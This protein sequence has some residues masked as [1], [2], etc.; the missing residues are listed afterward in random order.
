MPRRFSG[1]SLSAPDAL[2]RIYAAKAVLRERA[3][4]LVPYAV[5]RARA[6]ARLSERRPFLRALRAWAPPAVIAEIK[7][8][9]PSAGRIAAHFDV[10]AIAR[11]YEAAGAAAVSVLTERDNFLGDI[12]HLDLARGATSLPLLRK[13]F[14]RTRYDVAESA[15]AGADCILLILAAMSDAELRE[16]LD[17]AADYGLDVLVEVHDEAELHRATLAGAK[18]IGINNRDLRTLK[19]DLAVSDRLLPAARA[20]A[21]AVSESGIHTRAHAARLRAAGAG[22]FLIGEALMRA[23]DLE[24]FMTMMRTPGLA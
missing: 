4:R 9:S 2:A 19:T 6:F 5:L 10:A 14:L 17:E 15:A 7:C 3:S 20:V 23:S 11:A 12:S 22:A 13:D 21:F 16:C 8:A 24:A 18:L 1:T